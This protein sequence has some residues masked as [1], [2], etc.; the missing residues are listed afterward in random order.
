[1]P[2]KPRL[3]RAV[4]DTLKPGGRFAIINWQ[5]RPRGETTILDE[6]RGPRTDLRLSPQ[7]TIYAAKVD[8]IKVV[9][10]ID[11]PPFHTVALLS[12]RT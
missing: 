1:V 5:Q 9:V 11:V 7:Q 6:P 3:V 10:T 8:G 2:D 12:Y 4:R